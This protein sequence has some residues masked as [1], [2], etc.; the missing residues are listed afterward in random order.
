M[1][2]FDCQCGVTRP[3]KPEENIYTLFL[4]V[5]DEIIPLNPVEIVNISVPYPFCH[6]I[7]RVVVVSQPS[8]I[9]TPILRCC[10]RCVAWQMSKEERVLIRPDFAF[11]TMT[12]LPTGSV[13]IATCGNH[14]IF[15][16]PF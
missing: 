8:R 14:Q 3:R 4:V 12:F 5:N 16:K 15:V 7:Q 9:V 6:Y 2:F 10:Q 11:A 13:L 1:F